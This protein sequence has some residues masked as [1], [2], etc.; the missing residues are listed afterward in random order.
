MRT[1]THTLNTALVLRKR[2]AAA[3]C[4]VSV[5][6]LDRRRSSGSFVR[7]VQISTQT[8][9]FFRSDVETWL[10]SRPVLKR[11]ADCLDLY[12]AIND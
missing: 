5:A 1:K 3:L 11:F 7:P 2:Q 4:G 6:T 12:E 9:G 10:A 8:I